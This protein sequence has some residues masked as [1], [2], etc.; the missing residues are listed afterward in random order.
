[1]TCM[2]MLLTWCMSL[3]ATPSS[4]L[5]SPSPPPACW[6]QL[7]RRLASFPPQPSRKLKAMVTLRALLDPF[8]T[9]QSKAETGRQES[10]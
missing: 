10:W 3:A 5:S 1:M 2:M 8:A 7:F 6:V 9:V 4:A